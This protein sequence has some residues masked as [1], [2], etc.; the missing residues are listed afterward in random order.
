MTEKKICKCCGKYELDKESLYE[1]C[2]ICGWESD[3]IQEDNPNR[4]GGANELSLNDYKEKYFKGNLKALL[5]K[6][7]NDFDAYRVNEYFATDFVDDWD[8]YLNNGVPQRILEYLND[9]FYDIDTSRKDV[10]FLERRIKETLTIALEMLK[11][12]DK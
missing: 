4:S 6:F 12:L 1:I 11:E 7:L 5:E 9:K 8:D 2:P 10:K 3:P